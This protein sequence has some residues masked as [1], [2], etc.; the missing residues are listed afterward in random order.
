MFQ[1]PRHKKLNSKAKRYFDCTNKNDK[2]KTPLFDNQSNFLYKDKLI[3][4]LCFL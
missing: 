2:I 1:D 3:I 4:L